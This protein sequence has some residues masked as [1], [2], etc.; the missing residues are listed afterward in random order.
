[1]TDSVVE[2]IDDIDIN[3]IKEL[4]P[5]RYPMLLVDKLKDIH[6]GEKAVGIK[7]VTVN[8]PFFQ[9]HFP[10]KPVMPGVLIVEAM[11]Q[12]A[13]A[14]VMLTLGSD[15]EGKLVYFMSIDGAK[16]R[17]PVVP[18]DMLELHVQ[19]EQNRRSIWK[20]SAQGKVDGKVVAEATYT[21]MIAG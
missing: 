18:G 7:A 17:K 16:F 8:E 19:K 15:A 6:L 2:K 11:A 21:A 14:L 3:R 9:G 13:A 4:I 5:H 10:E 12:T 1:M 20:F